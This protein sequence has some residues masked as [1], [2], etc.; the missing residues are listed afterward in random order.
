[1]DGAIGL[2][3]TPS[4][5]L[6]EATRYASCVPPSF[7]NASAKRCKTPPKM[8]GSGSARFSSNDLL[9]NLLHLRSPPSKSGAPVAT[10]GSV[11]CLRMLT[12][13]ELPPG[14]KIVHSLY[15]MPVT[16]MVRLAIKSCL[17]SSGMHFSS[18][19]TTLCSKRRCASERWISK[20]RSR[21]LSKGV[22]VSHRS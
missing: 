4:S 3:S 11:S 19:G 13:S 22:D 17:M 21:I 7:P 14:W 12:L 10:F 6:T 9:I 15:M 1:M 16:V 2:M 20:G 5:C 18:I 8:I